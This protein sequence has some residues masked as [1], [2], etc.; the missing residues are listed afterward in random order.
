MP[1]SIVEPHRGA[2]PRRAADLKAIFSPANLKLRANE[3]HAN[4]WLPWLALYTG[5]RLEELG[6]LQV[7]DVRQEGNV[8]YLAIEPGDGKRVKTKS[9][10][11]RVPIHPRLIKL[12]LLS[13]AQEQKAAVGPDGR[14]HTNLF[15]GLVSTSYG[16][17]TA[18]FS[19]WWGRHARTV[20]GIPDPRKVW[21]SFRHGWKD[22]ARGVMPEEHHDA[23]T[24]HGNGSVGRSYGQGV[25][26][27]VLAESMA[28]VKFNLS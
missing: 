7:E 1:S 24:G 26:L 20:C 11:R 13:F 25:P 9:S 3:G 23:I 14:S 8:W 22:A 21:H 16:S 15:P 4:Y 5:A 17:R 28:R 6:Q 10:K 19:K 12:G 2:G 18:V 27:K